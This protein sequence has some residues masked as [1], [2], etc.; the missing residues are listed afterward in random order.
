MPGLYNLEQLDVGDNSIREIFENSF[1]P[2]GRRHP[3]HEQK[4]ERGGT[5]NH[6][7]TSCAYIG[8][9]ATCRSMCTYSV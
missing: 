6:G 9:S 7:A 2:F 1:D 3:S 8:R 4:K 5:F